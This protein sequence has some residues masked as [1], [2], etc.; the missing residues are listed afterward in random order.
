MTGTQGWLTAHGAVVDVFIQDPTGTHGGF[1]M[2]SANVDSILNY[3]MECFETGFMTAKPADE[4]VS[5]VLYPNPA[6]DQI[7]IGFPSDM[8]SMVVCKVFDARGVVV[9]ALY[10]SSVIDVSALAK[11]IYWVQWEYAGV[12]SGV[13]RFV[14]N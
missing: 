4:M 5:P 10:G 9:A 14:K 8:L 11:G 12:H 7:R 3:Y 6:T 13:A 2:N 1:H